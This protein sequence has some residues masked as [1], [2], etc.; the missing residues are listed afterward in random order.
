MRTSEKQIGDYDNLM[1]EL[2]NLNGYMRGLAGGGLGFWG[3]IETYA[4]FRVMTAPEADVLWFTGAL[5]FFCFGLASC[6]A[7]WVVFVP[8]VGLGRGLARTMRR[9]RLDISLILVLSVFL[10]AGLFFFLSYF[11]EV[12][13]R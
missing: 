13:A 4:G 3:I 10:V 9:I 2:E 7:A 11:S 8:H 6:L 5:V 1:E 12:H